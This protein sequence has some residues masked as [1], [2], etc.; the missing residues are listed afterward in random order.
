M[1]KNNFGS[2]FSLSY[3]T[4]NRIKKKGWYPWIIQPNL[5][6]FKE[7]GSSGGCQQKNWPVSCLLSEMLIK[8]FKIE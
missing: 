3:D 2:L 6:T 5:L 8:A 1:A 4:I 7:C